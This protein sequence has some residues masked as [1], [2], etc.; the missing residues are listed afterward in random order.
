M[1]GYNTPVNMSLEVLKRSSFGV[2]S[3]PLVYRMMRFTSGMHQSPAWG[4]REEIPHFRLWSSSYPLVSLFIFRMKSS[5]GN[6]VEMPL[7]FLYLPHGCLLPSSTLPH[8][9]LLF[10]F[11]FPHVYQFWSASFFSIESSHFLFIFLKMK[12]ITPKNVYSRV[13]VSFSRK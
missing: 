4:P 1:S 11:S 2:S 7:P 6:M 10:S 13:D 3:S 5:R 12:Q 8:S 9:F